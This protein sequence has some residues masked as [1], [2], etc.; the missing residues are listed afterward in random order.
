[1]AI[2]KR[3]AEPQ[4]TVPWHKR[5]AEPQQGTVPWIKREAE[6]QQGT[7]PS[8]YLDGFIEILTF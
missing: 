2:D 8:H 5:E 3:E 6:P 4:G 1:M 7:V